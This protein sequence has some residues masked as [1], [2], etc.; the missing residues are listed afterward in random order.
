MAKK[1]T[2]DKKRSEMKTIMESL[3]GEK[4]WKPAEVAAVIGCTPSNISSWKA[5]KNM[6]TN[7]AR[8]AMAI[9]PAKS[10]PASRG[11]MVTAV[12]SA[13]HH[14]EVAAR[15]VAEIQNDYDGFLQRAVESRDHGIKYHSK[16]LADAS[17]KAGKAHLAAGARLTAMSTGNKDF[18]HWEQEYLIDYISKK[19]YDNN[20]KTGYEY[21]MDYHT[22]SLAEDTATTPD[23][24][25]ATAQSNQDNAAK[26]AT[27][28]LAKATKHLKDM[29]KVLAKW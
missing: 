14:V 29:E 21:D 10:D 3:L 12:D 27:K 9:L 25:A 28:Q 13:K 7:E 26:Y 2:N 24:L 19:Q 1:I 4:G 11:F 20:T 15:H 18:R 5:G 6:G 22:K 17:E 8:R 23:M 16:E